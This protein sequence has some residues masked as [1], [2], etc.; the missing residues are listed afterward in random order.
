[1]LTQSRL[2]QRSAHMP[3]S[4]VVFGL[5][6]CSTN[7]NVRLSAWSPSQHSQ[8]LIW[9]PQPCV[10]VCMYVHICP[11]TYFYMLLYVTK[12]FSTFLNILSGHHSPGRAPGQPELW[13]ARRGLQPVLPRPLLPHLQEGRWLSFDGADIR[14]SHLS[15]T[16]CL[17]Q[18][19]Y[20]TSDTYGVWASKLEDDR[21]PVPYAWRSP[22]RDCATRAICYAMV[23]YDM[24]CYAMLCMLCYDMICYIIL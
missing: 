20:T 5:R 12:C 21:A 1:M 4:G 14:G 11:Y 7:S 2:T 19:Y 18:V 10:N 8:S 17:T 9:S 24:L 15:D 3:D 13:Q 6:T 16:T 23:W 22:R